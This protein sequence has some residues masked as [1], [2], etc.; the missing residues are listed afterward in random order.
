[1]LVEEDAETFV[2]AS[3]TVVMLIAE[4]AEEL[5]DSPAELIALTTKVVLPTERPEIVMGED[6]P[7]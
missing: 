7:V 4:D 6:E 1:L 3:G 2:G 5:A